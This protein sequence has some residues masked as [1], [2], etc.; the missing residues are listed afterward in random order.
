MLLTLSWF[1]AINTKS[2]TEKQLELMRQAAVLTSYNIYI[3]AVPLLEEAAGYNTKYTV[4]AENELKLVYIA[5]LDNRGFPRKYTGLLEKQMSRRDVP[6]DIFA[7]AADYYMKTS[8]TQDALA[9]L[10]KGIEKTGSSELVS[11]YESSRYSY[12]LS[13]ISYE[14]V[15]AIYKS[16]VQVCN[17]GLWGIAKTDGTVMIPCEYE[18]VSTFS[19]NRAIVKK[20]DEVYA[21]D[22]N[23]NRIAVAGN[24]VRDFGNLADNRIPLL[25]ENSWRRA[26]EE[27][28][29]GA[30]AFEELGMYSGG[31]AAAKVNGKWG[32][33]DK[34]SRWLIPAEYDGVVQDEL[35][36]CY[37]RGTVFMRKGSSVYLF[38]GG[39]QIEEAFDDALP[40]C[41]EGYAAVKRNGKWG[42]IDTDGHLKIQYIF[43]DALSFGQHMAAVKTGDLW[44][45]I[46]INGFIVIDALFYDAK[47]FSNGSAPVL[48]ERGWQFITLIE[49]KQEVGL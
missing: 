13:R 32:V 21:V 46:N 36:R 1:A 22:R 3:R 40:F 45:Y 37:A 16:T 35:G 43:D 33:V 29:L 2:T 47:S 8:K 17:D 4:T 44:G 24:G 11:M 34:A 10:R 28:E 41:D 25:I 26:S 18:K 14:K 27:L 9:V 15:T 31:Y 48:T 39:K 19:S 20:G 6:A 30:S 7:E 38:L 42:F 23:N 5:L 12:E 49:Y